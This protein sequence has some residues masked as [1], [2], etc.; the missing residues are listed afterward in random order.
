MCK[1][2]FERIENNE[3]KKGKGSGF[4]CEINNNFPIRYGLF[5]SNHI[6]NKSSIDYGNTIDF[7]YFEFQ[8]SFF[9][10]SYNRAKKQIKIT[11][12]RKVFTNEELDYTC[13][14]L[15]ESDG[16]IDYFKIEPNIF[17]YNKEILKNND[18]FILQFPKGNDISFSVGKVLFFENNNIVHN[19]PTEDGSSGSP[20]IKRCKDNSNKYLYNLATS[21][22]LILDDI[23]KQINEINCIY[24][25]NENEINLIHDYNANISNWNKDTQ[26]LYL[27]AKNINKKIFEDNI[28]LYVNQKK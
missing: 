14:E 19:A 12:G 9:S 21:F 24:I 7:E 20:V 18:I 26:K 1:I 25:L 8:K 5:T 2:S 22:D 17:K 28:E 10:S 11:E 3:L 4:F 6:L 15:F 23:K 13:I 27:E 16:I